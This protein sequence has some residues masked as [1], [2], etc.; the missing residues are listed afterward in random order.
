MPTI[1]TNRA[2]RISAGLSKLAKASWNEYAIYEGDCEIFSCVAT[3]ES[4]AEQIYRLKFSVTGEAQ[5]FI[6]KR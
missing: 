5:I 1:L 3:S 2:Q 4:H 6:V